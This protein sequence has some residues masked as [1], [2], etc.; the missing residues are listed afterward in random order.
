VTTILVTGA[1]TG[2][3]YATALRLSKNATVFAGVRSESDYAA[4]G[5]LGENI[6]P[7]YL[8]V[9]DRDSIA[10]A[11]TTI[12]EK[13]GGRLDALVNNAGIVVAGPLELIEPEQFERQ[14]AVNVMGPLYVSQAFLPMIRA[15]KG[16]I[17]TIGSIGGKMSMPY[18][19]PYSASKFAIEA[20]T[21]ALR[22]EMLPFGVKVILIEPG[23]IKTPLWQR[24]QAAGKATAERLSPEGL[25]L[26]GEPIR[27][28]QAFSSKIEDGAIGPERVAEVI[29]RALTA[30]SPQ[31]RYVVGTD[32]R[33]QLVIARL[34]EAIRDR[35]IGSLL[36]RA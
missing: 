26:Y 19:G 35:L 30:R 34:P 12:A 14:F 1:S 24:T 20:M 5:A 9:T 31:A 23:A 15:A 11:K 17:V 16:R 18:V 21:D 7:V 33:V 28:M 8:E 32:A 4:M 27:K 22:I 10:R 36:A 25:A 6:V 13:T 3:G 29:E 2:I